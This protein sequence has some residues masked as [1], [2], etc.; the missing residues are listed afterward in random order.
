MLVPAVQ[1]GKLKHPKGEHLWALYKQAIPG[2]QIVAVDII[3][4]LPETANGNSYVLVVG[5]Y[6]TRWMEAYTIRNQETVTA[7]QKLVDEFFRRFSTPE[8]PYSD[9]G[10]Q[11]E[12]RLISEI[13]KLLNMQKSYHTI[14]PSGRWPLNQTLLD[15]LSTTVHSHPL[16]WEENITKVC[17]AHNTSVKA[18]T[19]YSPF[20]LMFGRNACL[21]VDV[22]FPTDKPAADVSFGEYAKMT[23]ESMEKAFNI[24]RVHV[25][26]KQC[27]TPCKS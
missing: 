20:Y 23:S 21:P 1:Q 3:C 17:M 7:A 2:V 25:G 8:Q 12:S 26:E 4:P 9:Q 18:T 14:P 24:A 5:N 15:K 22:M 16:D 27:G 6:F 10:S 11:F 13:C 19:E